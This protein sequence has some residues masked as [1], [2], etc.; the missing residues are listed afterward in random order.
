MTL[1]EL[2]IGL[3]N[4]GQR[5]DPCDRDL[6]AAGGQQPRKLREHVRSRGCMIP[7]R[8]HTIL[9]RGGEVDDRVD[10]IRR[11]V[12]LKRKFDVP[13]TVCVNEGVDFPY[14]CSADPILNP[15]AIG[16]RNYAMIGEP[17]VIRV[18]G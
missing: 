7:F 15:V 9:S 18:T 8:L 1:L 11:D 5:I 13:S 2:S 3:A 14:G 10:S 16:N 4:F 17:L 12:Q 6:Q